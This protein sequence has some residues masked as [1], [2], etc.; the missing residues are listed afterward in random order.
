MPPPASRAPRSN[1]DWPATETPRRKTDGALARGQ[2]Q[3]DM[4]WSKDGIADNWH[5]AGRR[6]KATQN[7]YCTG[8]GEARY[9]RTQWTALS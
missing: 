3:N 5:R 7:T 4:A 2:K 9:L 6:A 1:G 8:R